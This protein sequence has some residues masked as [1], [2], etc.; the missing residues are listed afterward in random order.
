M[1]SIGVLQASRDATF[2]CEEFMANEQQK[3]RCLLVIGLIVFLQ[4][5]ILKSP[6]T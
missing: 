2:R 1:R 6:S 5:E 4:A 3:V